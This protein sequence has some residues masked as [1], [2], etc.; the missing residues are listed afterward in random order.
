MPT[1]THE[2]PWVTARYVNFFDFLGS[3]RANI[4]LADKCIQAG[5]ISQSDK[6]KFAMR[7]GPKFIDLARASK[8]R[9][10]N[11]PAVLQSAGQII[12]TTTFN[13]KGFSTGMFE[14]FMPRLVQANE[15]RK[16]DDEDEYDD[17][18]RIE[19]WTE[20]KYNYLDG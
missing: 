19:S 8:C 15:A 4:V 5:L 13:S 18:M 10:V 16:G 9:L 6:S 3:E 11:Y 12:G 1:T 2:D 14:K 20:G 17:M 7:W